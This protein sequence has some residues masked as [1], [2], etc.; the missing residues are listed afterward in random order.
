M[1]C[2]CF[3]NEHLPNLQKYHFFLSS[4]LKIHFDAKNE[5]ILQKVRKKNGNCNY[6]FFFD[7]F[8]ANIL[9]QKENITFVI[10]GQI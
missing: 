4:Q 8:G 7:S 2:S 6:R 1:C 9:N 10:Q 3:R 5:E